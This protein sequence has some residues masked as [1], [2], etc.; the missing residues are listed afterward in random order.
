M[1]KGKEYFDRERKKAMRN[2]W[3]WTVLSVA[4]LAMAAIVYELGLGCIAAPFIFTW[5]ICG[6]LAIGMIYGLVAQ[7]EEEKEEMDRWEKM[8][9]INRMMES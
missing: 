3:V 9:K 2:F 8:Q 1:I 5:F 6:M 7:R 4:S